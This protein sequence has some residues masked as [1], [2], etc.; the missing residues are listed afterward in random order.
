LCIARTCL[1]GSKEK[2]PLETTSDGSTQYSQ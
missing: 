1:H 2:P